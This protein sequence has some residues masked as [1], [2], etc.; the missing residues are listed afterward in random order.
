MYL[1]QCPT[2][3][4]ACSHA[5]QYVSSLTGE[6]RVFRSHDS[7][8]ELP[9]AL[10]TLARLSSQDECNSISAGTARPAAVCE[11][12]SEKESAGG[13]R[14]RPAGCVARPFVF[15]P[16]FLLSATQNVT[17]CENGLKSVSLSETSYFRPP[18]ST[19]R[20]NELTFQATL[21]GS[22]QESHTRC[23]L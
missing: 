16:L 5:V 2:Q 23:Q 7:D 8:S 4:P 15:Q 9:P 17:L 6:C 10:I 19:N 12:R 3:P 11:C 18:A 21:T 14:C 1:L 22:Y 13:R 20:S